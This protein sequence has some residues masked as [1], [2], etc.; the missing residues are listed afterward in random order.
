[1]YS[2]VKITSKTCTPCKILSEDFEEV[3]ETFPE[4]NIEEIELNDTV[5]EK[6]K[7]EKIPLLILTEN[8]N[9]IGRLQNSRI[10]KVMEWL[11]LFLVKTEDF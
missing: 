9:E 6:F 7:V 5:K 4:L 3:T 1:M 10:D 2:L 8:N 11:K